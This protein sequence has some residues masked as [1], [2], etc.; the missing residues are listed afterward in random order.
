MKRKHTPRFAQ[1]AAGANVRVS[2]SVDDWVADVGICRGTF[3]A[4][5]GDRAPR[6]TTVGRRRLIMEAPRDYLAR[7]SQ[8]ELQTCE[9]G[10]SQ[11]LDAALRREAV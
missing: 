9:P 5:K 3:Y 1:D 10:L 8:T 4:L 7:M 6:S 2:W 11:M